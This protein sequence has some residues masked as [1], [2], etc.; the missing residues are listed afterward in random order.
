MLDCMY[1]LEVGGMQ[2]ENK[3]KGAIEMVDVEINVD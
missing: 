3:D 1:H 2:L